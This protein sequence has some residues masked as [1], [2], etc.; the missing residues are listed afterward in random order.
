MTLHTL[1]FL[2]EGEDVTVG[3]RDTDSY[4]VLPADG[5]ALLRELERG[6]TPHDAAQWYSN[7][8]DQSVDMAEFLEAV[9]ELGFIATAEE[10]PATAGRVRR[11]RFGKMM[12]SPAGWLAGWLAGI[13]CA[14][15][16]PV[17]DSHDPDAVLSGSSLYC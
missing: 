9:N 10:K 15:L 12:F 7:T 5:A 4:C 3:R 2:D 8:Y 17:P 16:H 11:Q 13:C 1:T 14:V 6:S